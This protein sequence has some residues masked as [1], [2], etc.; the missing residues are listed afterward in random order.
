MLGLILLVLLNIFIIPLLAVCNDE[1]DFD[2]MGWGVDENEPS[3][4]GVALYEDA[5]D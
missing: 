2:V 5:L 3:A 1:L 4:C